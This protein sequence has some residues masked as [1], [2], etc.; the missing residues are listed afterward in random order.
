MRH[1]H[2]HPKGFIPDTFVIAG[3]LAAAIF[4]I[5]V[6]MAANVSLNSGFGG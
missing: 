1:H 2:P 5:A 3:V 6:A 4:L